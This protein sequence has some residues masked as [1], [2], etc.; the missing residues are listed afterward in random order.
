VRVDL[1]G[2]GPRF[3]LEAFVARGA[4]GSVY[5][6]V[7]RETGAPVAVKR[8]HEHLCEP[9]MIARF[10]R[11]ARLLAALDSPHVVRHV[12]H[13]RDDQR[14]PFLALE[15]L[16]GEDL[17]QWR[18]GGRATRRLVVEIAR[19][20]ALGLAA[21]HDVGIVH[22][23]VKP[24]NFFLLGSP[25]GSRVKLIDLGVA[26]VSGESTLTENGFT[27]GTPAYMSPEQASGA[28]D[29]TASADIFS[30][31][32]VLFELIAGQKP[33]RGDDMVALAMKIVLQDPPRLRD[34]VPGAPAELD[35]VVAR[36]MAKLPDDRFS[37]AHAMAD[38]LARLA[39][40]DDGGAAD[41]LMERLVIADGT[42]TT[43][44]PSLALSLPLGLERRVVT[45]LFASCEGTSEPAV[46]I[47]AFREAVER[48]GGTFHRALGPRRAAVFGAS[49]GRGDEAL[50]AARAALALAS[51]TGIRLAI[52]TGRAL[53]S[54]AS[55]SGGL[56]DRGLAEVKRSHGEVRVDETTARL[57]EGRF[58]V[59]GPRGERVLRA[60]EPEP[61][62][63]GPRL[64]GRAGVLVGRDR[65]AAALLATYEQC[66]AEPVARAVLLTGAAG[67]GKSRLR[68]ELCRRVAAG[69]TPPTVLHGRG[70]PHGVGSPFGLLAPAIRRLAGILDGEPIAEQRRRLTS[71]VATTAHH[72][73]G[74][75][76]LEAAS[77]QPWCWRVSTFL[78]EL[79]R[80]PFGDEAEPT[81]PAARRSPMVINDAMRAAWEDWVA[82]E[83]AVRPLLIV[84]EDLHWGDLPSV[85]FV[86]AALRHVPDG[87]LMVLAAARP[88]VH[89]RFPRLFAGR[90]LEEVRVAALTRRAAEKLVRHAL[91]AEARDEVV[92]RVVD[93]ADG[94]AFY[95]EEIVR[96]VAEGNADELPETV[97][98]M[99]QARLDA[100]GAEAKRL[101]RAASVFGRT[102]W[103]GGVRALLG[104]G[105]AAAPA[106]LTDLEAS[107]MVQRSREASLPGET[108]HTF[109]HALVRD[110]AYA[111]LPDEDRVR[112]HRL[113]GEW[114]AAHG[115]RDAVALAEHFT[116][117]G[118][119]EEARAWYR[120]AASQAL[121]ASDLAAAIERA[122]R[123]V[124]AGATGELLGAL[125][126][127]QAEA[128]RFRG[129]LAQA[130]AR[131]EE[132]FAQLPVASP[133]YYRAAGE[134]AAAAGLL[135]HVDRVEAVARALPADA[136]DPRLRSTVLVCLCRAAIPL[137][138]AGH[139]AAGALFARVDAL[140]EPLAALDPEARALVCFSRA[141]RALHAGRPEEHLV[142]QRAA[143]AAFAAGGDLRNAVNRQVAVGFGQTELGLLADAE[144]TL[145]AA[146]AAGERLGIFNVSVRAWNNLGHVLGRLGRL[147]EAREAEQRAIDGCVAQGDPRLES[148][149]RLYLSEI[150]LL[151]GD[152]PGAS[153]EASAALALASTTP[154]GRARALAALARIAL[155]EGRVPDAVSA[156]VDAVQL[157]EGLGQLDEGESMIRL[158]LAEARLAAG[159]EA[160]AKDAVAVAARRVRE[161]AA[162]IDAPAWRESFLAIPE[163]A[164]TLRLE[165][166][167]VP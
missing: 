65:E 16:E 118:V 85:T 32:V 60:A 152:L 24:S 1:E 159:E 72:A 112:G 149:S 28:R 21:L 140:A 30:L 107:E 47:E 8:L 115:A 77:L 131:A 143:E 37:S 82:A 19:Q 80:V 25:S 145:R 23:D 105:G 36:A 92:R 64:L 102:F 109:T 146:L 27:L 154:G 10:E 5:R 133:P 45:G 56:I 49:R 128:H 12:A 15:W 74:A 40:S 46:A 164:E 111:M 144:E 104:E 34:L 99:V 35:A 98:G 132:A 83:C 51:I 165:A 43:G 63:F 68:Y 150:L 22:R 50:R 129:E 4:W 155:R 151:S 33:Y 163:N 125:R 93:R 94:N 59:D 67:T 38:A 62:A 52:V 73:A 79:A 161:R 17:A 57:L 66:V 53:T 148:A 121:E 101:L 108:E 134:L 7:D 54:D 70:E 2:L 156:A 75:G 48:H 147:A 14:R 113:A 160:R 122:E 87:P 71:L 44:T 58:A 96:A 162:T 142:Q 97:L 95:L 89:E 166:R 9:Q 136:P 55:L 6:G 135:G 116:L 29:P 124:S 106:L 110:A 123:G 130:E 76:H 31:G 114:L 103:L 39:V 127:I 3:R 42:P 153:R 91:G 26:R 84:L 61:D 138:W 69:P 86:D 117:G 167:L 41:A 20:A 100:L 141:T 81:L 119:P 137:F 158:A 90:D 126:L 139:A 13:G 11:E 157:L 88:E 18:K 120:R 78:G